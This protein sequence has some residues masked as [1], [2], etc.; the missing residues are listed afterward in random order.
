MLG[1]CRSN[2]CARNTGA[3]NKG[4][5]FG[6]HIVIVAIKYHKRIIV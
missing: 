2:V 3:Q 1:W 6:A 5:S 4:Y